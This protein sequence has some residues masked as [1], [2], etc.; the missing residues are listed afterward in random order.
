[1][2]AIYKQLVFNPI[3]AVFNFIYQHLAF[4]DFGFAII[5]LTVLVRVILFPIFYAAA[6]QQTIIQKLQPK[7]KSIQKE[8]KDNK[9][10][11]VK[12]LMSLYAEHKINPLA[13]LFL[14]AVQLPIL[15]TLY[16][17]ILKNGSHF[18]N[19]IFLGFINLRE[20]SLIIAALAAVAQFLSA[21]L[22]LNHKPSGANPNSTSGLAMPFIGAAI[23]L[24]F[25]TNLP[26]SIGIYWITTTLISIVQQII[27]NRNVYGRDTHQN[28]K[29]S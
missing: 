17:V 14:F 16:Y 27:I 26:A 15:I 25:L 20:R 28:S 23:T 21:F 3:L 6:K 22:A 24:V 13:N 2:S 12:A 18:D 8:L 5:I 10:E 7:I 4:G 29:V 19:F 1:M 11:Q 9:E